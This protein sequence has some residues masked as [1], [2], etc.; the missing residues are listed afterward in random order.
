MNALSPMEFIVFI[1][2]GAAL[3][4]AYFALL[5]HAVRLHAAETGA[6][7][8]FPFLAL[9]IVLAAG[10]FWFAARQGAAP[11]LLSLFGFLAARTAAQRWMRVD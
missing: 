3:G 4:G 10:V 2:L 9:R 7:L 6:G 8:F 11:L 1:S 5:R